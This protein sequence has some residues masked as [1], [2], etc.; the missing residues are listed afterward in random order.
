MQLR[1]FEFENNT[2]NLDLVPAPKLRKN[3]SIKYARASPLACISAW[4]WSHPVM[5]PFKFDS[6]QIKCKWLF[7]LRAEFVQR[8]TLMQVPPWS[9]CWPVQLLLLF[10]FKFLVLARF[11][12]LSKIKWEKLR[13]TCLA[14]D[15]IW[16]VDTVAIQLGWRNCNWRRPVGSG[17]EQESFAFKYCLMLIKTWHECFR[18]KFDWNVNFF[19]GLRTFPFFSFVF[20]CFHVSE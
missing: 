16:L 4:N 14:R 10:K 17:L 1:R 3:L 12:S 13:N 7:N 6:N 20:F 18:K 11:M 5:N 15:L 8:W 2:L 19:Y 9:T